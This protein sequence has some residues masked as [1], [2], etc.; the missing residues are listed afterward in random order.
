MFRFAVQ[1][2][3]TN[4]KATKAKNMI[5]GTL[6]VAVARSRFKGADDMTKKEKKPGG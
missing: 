4:V 1:K 5:K 3:M 6:E 2:V